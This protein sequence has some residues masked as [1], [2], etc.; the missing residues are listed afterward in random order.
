MASR[1]AEVAALA[2]RAKKAGWDVSQPQSASG[3]YRIVAKNG[4]TTVLH[5]TGEAHATD[6]A[7]RNFLQHG[8]LAADE[9]AAAAEAKRVKALKAAAAERALAARAAKAAQQSA[10][11]AKAAGP[12]AGPED[13]ELAWFQAEHPGP[14]MRWANI[15]PELAKQLLQMNTDNRPMNYRT[16]EH[17]QAI[18]DSGHWHLTHQGMAIDI[19]GVLQDGQHRLQACVD[20][21]RPISAAFFVGMDPSNFKAIDEGRNRKFADLLGKDG[22]IDTNLL[23]G[24][25][26]LVT[27]Y[28]EPYPRAYL[29]SKITN[30]TLY[31]S[32]KGDPER[33]ATAV[34]WGR[35]N[36]Q[37]A[38]VVGGA[39]SAARYLILDANGVDNQYVHA[40]F[41]GLANGSKPSRML[42][43]EDDPRA[44]ARKVME[45]RRG[46]G[47]RLNAIE[48]V[49][50]V[51]SAWNQL[52]VGRRGAAYLRWAETQQDIPSISICLDKG[53]TASAPPDFLLGEFVKDGDAR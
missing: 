40:F 2:M 18:I 21:G 17:Y 46:R 9:K 16:V 12:Y 20:S 33:L 23:S 41:E 35:K 39:L 44:L 10:L 32:F 50:I 28:R 15:T 27:A 38:H 6:Q 19:R 30:E 25:V 26:R 31:D 43:D 7:L 24:T 37:K 8:N 22:E 5:S 51:I 53:R 1:R 45:N 48:Q 36:H 3:G 29:R 42:L 47:K 49:G 52:V 13:V 11:T 34:R 14:W 4:W